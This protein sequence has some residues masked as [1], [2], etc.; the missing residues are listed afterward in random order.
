[1]P[2]V[3]ETDKFVLHE[4]FVGLLQGDQK[5]FVHMMIV[6]QSSG[7]QTLFDHPVQYNMSMCSC[8]NLD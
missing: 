8:I 2:C 6:L 4:P 1:M 7:A 3:V 5:V